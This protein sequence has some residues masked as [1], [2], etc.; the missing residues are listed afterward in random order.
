M[1][2]Q[3]DSRGAAAGSDGATSVG[4]PAGQG[5][6]SRR[7]VGATARCSKL[8]AVARQGDIRGAAAGSDGATSVGAPAG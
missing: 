8:R 3:G 2:R 5:D 7:L 1:A 6:D 4:A